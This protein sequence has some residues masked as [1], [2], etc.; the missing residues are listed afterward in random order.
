MDHQPAD[1]TQLLLGL[2]AGDKDAESQLLQT[3]Y[4][5]LHR[6]AGR[7]MSRER[8][9]HTLQAT[10]L[11]NEAYVR[12]IDQRGKDWHSRAHFFGIAA[13]VMRRVLVDHARAKGREKR[14]GRQTKVTVDEAHPLTIERADEVVALDEALSRLA[15]IDPRQ[16]RVVELRFFG[17]MTEEETAEVLGV[18]SRTVK[19][20]WSMARAWLYGELNKEAP[21][22]RP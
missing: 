9:D 6:M 10:A 5:E 13:H 7:L 3:V 19:R 16:S 20:D 14:G 11:I 12:L 22:V 15:K 1:V 8:P 18:S 21:D 4:T 17:G 2:K